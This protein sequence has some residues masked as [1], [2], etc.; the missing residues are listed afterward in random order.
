MSNLCAGMVLTFFIPTKWN[1]INSLRDFLIHLVTNS[2]T[3]SIIHLIE[4]VLYMTDKNKLN[5]T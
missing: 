2:L 3:H 4:I 5:V 1:I